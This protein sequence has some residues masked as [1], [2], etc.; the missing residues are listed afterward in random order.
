MVDLAAHYGWRA[1]FVEQS[2]REIVRRGGARVRVRNISLQ[3]VGFPD[4]VLVRERPAQIIFAE[5][6]RERDARHHGAYLEDAQKEWGRLLQALERR[7]VP[8]DDSQI[9]MG[10]AVDRHPAF[11]YHVWRPSDYNSVEE[12]LR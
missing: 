9:R 12:V 4:L 5:L 11:A 10:G 3:G 6:K 1:F 7:I 2:T 8:D